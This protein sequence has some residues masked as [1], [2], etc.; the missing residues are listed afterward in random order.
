MRGAERDLLADYLDELR[1][2]GV[3]APAFDDAWI[4]YR[5][6]VVYGFFLWAITMYVKPDIIAALLRRLG[7]AASELESYAA[8]S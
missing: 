6:G 1:G 5:R 3:D 2:Y 7:T 4:E 8:L